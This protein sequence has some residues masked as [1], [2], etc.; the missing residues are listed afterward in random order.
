MLHGGV[1]N[2]HDFAMVAAHAAF[3]AGDHFVFDADIGEGAAHHDFMMA[4]PRAVAVKVCF[5][6][7][8]F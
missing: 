4:A 1:V 6:N 3:D 7:L 5:A 2:G 8:M